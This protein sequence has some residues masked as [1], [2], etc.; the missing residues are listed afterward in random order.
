MIT[1]VPLVNTWPRDERDG[2]MKTP[3]TLYYSSKLL[4]STPHPCAKIH[5]VKKEAEYGD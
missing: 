3:L 2:A 4:K 5:S 1:Y